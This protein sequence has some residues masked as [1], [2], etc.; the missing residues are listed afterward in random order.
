[1]I[2]QKNIVIQSLVLRRNQEE[3]RQLFKESKR[4]SLKYFKN[5]GPLAI[6]EWED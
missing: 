6:V 3:I 1:M 5:G 2:F 4:W